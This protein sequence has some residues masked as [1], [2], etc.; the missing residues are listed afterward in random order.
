MPRTKKEQAPPPAPV[1]PIQ[2]AFCQKE[3]NPPTDAVTFIGIGKWRDGPGYFHAVCSAKTPDGQDNPCF[4]NG[5]AWATNNVKQ[6]PVCM[7]FEEWKARPIRRSVSATRAANGRYELRLTESHLNCIFFLETKHAPN[8][9]K[10]KNI[11]LFK[12]LCG[13]AGHGS[14]TLTGRFFSLPETCRARS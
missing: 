11:R 5:M 3:L 8:A 2:C 1:R 7:T 14:G 4:L 10:A 12:K 6:E 9:D 13:S